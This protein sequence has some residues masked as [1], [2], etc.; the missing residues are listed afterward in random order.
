[1]FR[2]LRIMSAPLIWLNQKESHRTTLP[3][4][5]H[6]NIVL[7]FRSKAP[8]QSLSKFFSTISCCAPE[9]RV[10]KMIPREII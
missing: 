10:F 4:D 2:F 5:G 7:I 8:Y 3:M 9:Q 6:F 1:M